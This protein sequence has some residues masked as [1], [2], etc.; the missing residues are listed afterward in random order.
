M[1]DRI[2]DAYGP[3]G[4]E[5]LDENQKA[6]AFSGNNRAQ[7]QALSEGKYTWREKGTQGPGTKLSDT[8]LEGDLKT[9]LAQGKQPVNVQGSVTLDLTPEARR[10]LTP[11]GGSNVIQLT[12]HERQSNAG[13]GNA[14]PNNAAPGEGPMTRGRSGW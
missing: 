14:R 11:Q 12:P 6:I 9:L 5:I 8:P 10:A 4:I 1:M 3:G 13:Y 7:L 2:I